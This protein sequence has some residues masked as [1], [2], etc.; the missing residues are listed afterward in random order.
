MATVDPTGAALAGSWRE[1]PLQRS[2]PMDASAIGANGSGNATQ[3]YATADHSSATDMAEDAAVTDAAMIDADHDMRGNTAGA[4]G[5]LPNLLSRD[6]NAS[7]P[8]A[9]EMPKLSALGVAIKELSPDLMTE[10]ETLMFVNG[11]THLSMSEM[12][13]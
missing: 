5:R 13:L 1:D 7:M 8:D 12:V 6:K 11:W 4:G 10:L 3:Q 9:Q 2:S